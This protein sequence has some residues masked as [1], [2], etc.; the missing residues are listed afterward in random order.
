MF[1]INAISDYAKGCCRLTG[2]CEFLTEEDVLGQVVDDMSSK[3]F[4]WD[5]SVHHFLF[6]LFKLTVSPGTTTNSPRH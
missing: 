1:S 6:L 3:E 4:V 5:F 2:V